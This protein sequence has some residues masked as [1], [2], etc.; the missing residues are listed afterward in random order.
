MNKQ[1]MIIEIKKHTDKNGDFYSRVWT[2]SGPV[3]LE[4]APERNIYAF[5]KR[6]TGNKAQ[7]R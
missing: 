5:Y 6:V 1:E 7:G 4:S 3:L 2:K